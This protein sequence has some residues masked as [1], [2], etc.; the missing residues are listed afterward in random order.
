MTAFVSVT[1][2]SVGRRE[3]ESVRES[4]KRNKLQSKIMFIISS[5]SALHF[6][7][8]RQSSNETLLGKF[9]GKKKVL[10]RELRFSRPEKNFSHHH[11]HTSINITSHPA[12]KKE[13]N[14]WYKRS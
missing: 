11:T 8:H 4:L 1:I 14:I 6:A 2:G 13:E 5:L 9:L 10:N 3:R 7:S 12:T